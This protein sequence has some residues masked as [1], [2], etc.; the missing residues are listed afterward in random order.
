VK[1]IEDDLRLRRAALIASMN[2]GDMSMVTPLSFAVR[3]VPRA[4]K[5]SSR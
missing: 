2:A 5:N 3:S 4:L 1:S